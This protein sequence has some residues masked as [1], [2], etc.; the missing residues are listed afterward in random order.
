MPIAGHVPREGGA[1]PHPQHFDLV[2][3]CHEFGLATAMIGGRASSTNRAL[4]RQAEAPAIAIE[5]RPCRP[6]AVQQVGRRASV[7]RT[8]TRSLGN[9]SSNSATRCVS[10]CAANPGTPELKRAIAARL[11]QFV[12]CRR[13]FHQCRRNASMI[14]LPGFR[15][16]EAPS[17]T[18]EQGHAKP[19]F[20]HLDVSADDGMI[21]AQAG[22]GLA[23]ASG[24]ADRFKGPQRGERRKS[25]GVQR[26]RVQVR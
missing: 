5:T 26:G 23:N 3:P 24:S 13:Q 20:D 1:R 21:E 9:M 15:Q 18:L 19:V 2:Q 14:I 6:R 8:S 12:R 17:C 25:L 11:L 7:G 16:I 4:C 22:C 10:H